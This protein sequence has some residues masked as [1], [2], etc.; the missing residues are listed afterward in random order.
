MAKNIEIKGLDK[1]IKDLRLLGKKGEDAIEDV[2][3]LTA[4]EIEL[5]ARNAAKVDNGALHLSMRATPISNI[6]TKKTVWKVYANAT[7]LARYAAYVEFGTGGLV[8][9][10]PEMYDIAIKFKGKGIKK[11]DLRPR[12]FLYPAFVKGRLNY[13]KDLEAEL[14]RLTKQV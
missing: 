5:N 12:P 4:R 10:P 1:L 3:E 14:K 9:V 6:K 11:I 8:E 13:I 2:T 7:G